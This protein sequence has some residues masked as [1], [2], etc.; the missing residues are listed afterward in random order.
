[1]SPKG[2]EVPCPL[3]LERHTKRQTAFSG[4]MRDSNSATMLSNRFVTQ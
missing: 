3:A 2:E 1:M 4:A